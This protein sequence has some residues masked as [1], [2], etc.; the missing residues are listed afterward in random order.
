MGFA[1][2]SATAQ[3]ADYRRGAGP[4]VEVDLSVLE[5][6]D[7]PLAAP[8]P[9]IPPPVVS[10]AAPPAFVRPGPPPAPAAAPATGPLPPP[11]EAGLRRMQREINAWALG[12]SGGVAAAS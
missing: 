12:Y 7:R 11:G 3:T 5:S 10:R 9:L 4:A 6:L 8:V 1:T 2:A